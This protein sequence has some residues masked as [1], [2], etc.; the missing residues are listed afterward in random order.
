V[1]KLR[2]CNNDYLKKINLIWGNRP[3]F[4][5]EKKDEKFV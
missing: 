5:E 3:N 1:E 4:Y 2:V